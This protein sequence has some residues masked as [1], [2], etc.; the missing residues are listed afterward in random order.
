MDPVDDLRVSNPASNEPLLTALAD[1]LV[2]HDFD[3]KSIMKVILESETYQRASEPLPENKADTRYFSRY[4]PRRLMAEVLHDAINGITLTNPDFN[5][6]ILSDGSRKKIEVYQKGTR[7]LELHDSAVESYFLKVFGRNNREIT[8]EC[9]RSNQPSLVQ[10]LH[11]SN[12]DTLNKN[13][14]RKNGIVDSLLQLDGGAGEIIDKAY[15]LCLSRSPTTKEKKQF[16]ALFGGDLRTDTEDLLWA[17][18]TSR[19]FLFQH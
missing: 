13:L 19:E 8:C 11:L 2:K 16:L 1:H 12:G 3:L 15:L 7:S 5:H 10:V 6:I 4:Y 17:L 18:M 9:E 14:A